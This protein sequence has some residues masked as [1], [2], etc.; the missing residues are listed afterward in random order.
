[1]NISE[2]KKD[3]IKVLENLDRS[4][5]RDENFRNFCEM[6]YCALAKKTAANETQAEKLEARYMSIVGS[7]K[8]K[9]DVREL[10]KLLSLNI[11]GLNK[12]RCDFLGDIAGEI[13]VLDKKNGQF[14][15]PYDISKML[16]L[17]SLPDIDALIKEDG[18]FTVSDP[19]AGAGCMILACADIVEERG[20]DFSECMSVHVTELSKMTYYMLFIHAKLEEED[21]Q[22]H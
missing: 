16:A 10:P 18:F 22:S 3:F 11:L 2:I 13:E 1:M 5:G 7:Y 4:K 8:N 21:P 17:V 20:Y 19:A 12:G 14:F 6:S 9:D 15:T